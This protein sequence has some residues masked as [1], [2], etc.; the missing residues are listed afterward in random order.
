MK[1]LADRDYSCSHS[2]IRGSLRLVVSRI[3]FRKLFSVSLTA[4]AFIGACAQDQNPT[5]DALGLF[6]SAWE[7]ECNVLR[8]NNPSTATCGNDTLIRDPSLGAWI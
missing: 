7:S 4:I 8:S 1:I 2:L 5:P 6:N 3:R